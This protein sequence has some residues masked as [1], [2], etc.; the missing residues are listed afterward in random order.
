MTNFQEK[1]SAYQNLPQE[2]VQSVQSLPSNIHP[3][4]SLA[5]GLQALGGACTHLCTN[6]RAKDLE[7]FDDAAALI[8]AALPTLASACHRKKVGQKYAY[9]INP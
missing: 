1:V 6:D 4:A 8:I 3:M 9:Q 5:S 2:V 7:N